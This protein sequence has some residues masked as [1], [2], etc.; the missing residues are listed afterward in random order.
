MNKKDDKIVKNEINIREIKEILKSYQKNS[1]SFG[2]KKINNIIN[3]IYF[4]LDSKNRKF[5]ID[6]P[7]DGLS[8]DNKFEISNLFVKLIKLNINF[9][10]LT[11]DALSFQFLRST[12]Y[13]EKKSKKLSTAILKKYDNVFLIDN[14]SEI[15]NILF[16]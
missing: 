8:Q 6:D 7:F 10:I 1:K 16:K 2:A 3:S 11:N 14:I 12:I 13:N 4:L 5:I 15:D 9:I